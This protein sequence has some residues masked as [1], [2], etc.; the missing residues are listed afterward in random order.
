MVHRR[1]ILLVHYIMIVA[2]DLTGSVECRRKG[3][4]NVCAGTR[5]AASRRIAKLS[6]VGVGMSLCTT[7]C[8][9]MVAQYFKKRRAFATAVGSSGASLAMLFIPMF[10]RFLLSFY[11]F[12]V[13]YVR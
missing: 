5:Y 13:R 10:I 3:V 11:R 4:R 7:A 1:C 9:L 8:Y 2:L 12:T 6:F